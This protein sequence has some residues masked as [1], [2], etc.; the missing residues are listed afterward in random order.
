MNTKTNTTID[1]KSALIGLAVGVLV[2]VG[3]GAA[4][5]SDRPV[6]RYQMVS[7]PNNGGQGGSHSL[8][9]DTVTGKVWLGF[10]SSSGKSDNEFFQPKTSER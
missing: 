6:G 8:I 5:S 4:A 2:T 10:L 1:I 9:I 3:V 7:N